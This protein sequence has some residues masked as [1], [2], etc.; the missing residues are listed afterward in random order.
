MNLIDRDSRRE[1]VGD[2]RSSEISAHVATRLHHESLL[3]DVQRMSPISLRLRL[4]GS[5]VL[6]KIRSQ[7]L[8]HGRRKRA[9][10][11]NGK[12]LAV[13]GDVLIDNGASGRLH[14]MKLEGFM[15]RHLDVGIHLDPIRFDRIDGA[16]ERRMD[17][18]RKPE[19]GCA[20]GHPSQPADAMERPQ[21]RRFCLNQA[22]KLL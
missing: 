2:I 14:F 3:L 1:Q 19:Q 12:Y 16:A 13:G 18:D 7:N 11:G 4:Q 15:L 8:L 21:G 22:V 9:V 5:C 6:L 17:W 10:P 20:G